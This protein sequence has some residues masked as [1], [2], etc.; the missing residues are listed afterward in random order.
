VQIEREKFR[1]FGVLMR[2]PSPVTRHLWSA[3]QR[4]HQQQLSEMDNDS[5]DDAAGDRGDDR[6]CGNTDRDD[7]VIHRESPQH[8]HGVRL[9]RSRE[10]MQGGGIES[11]DWSTVSVEAKLPKH[12][13][14]VDR[15]LKWSARVCGRFSAPIVVAMVL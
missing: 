10:C 9:D 5:D 1:V 15:Q 12:R 13:L 7:E 2:V 4:R 8:R 6:D 11:I 3:A 14:A